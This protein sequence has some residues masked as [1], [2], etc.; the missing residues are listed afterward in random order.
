MDHLVPLWPSTGDV[1]IIKLTHGDGYEIAVCPDAAQ[2]GCESYDDAW[3]TGRTLAESTDVDLWF[4]RPVATTPPEN[5]LR[6]LG[7]YRR[8][9]EIERN[10][11]VQ[12]NMSA[13]PSQGE[14]L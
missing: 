9:R 13:S 10:R 5:E 8:G 7:H 4:T 11:F 12:T 6:L 1:V 2:M 14:R 3:S